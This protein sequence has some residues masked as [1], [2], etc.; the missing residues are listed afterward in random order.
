MTA[1]ATT[2]SFLNPQELIDSSRPL[3]VRVPT[4]P[5]LLMGLFVLLL[6]SSSSQEPAIRVLQFA[7]LPLLLLMSI[8]L[9]VFRVRLARRA[10]AESEAVAALDEMIQLRRWPEAASLAHRVLSQPMFLPD[11]RLFALMSLAALLARYHRFSDAR[12]VHDTLLNPAPGEMVPD[13]SLAHSIKVARAMSLLRDDHLVDADRAMSDLRREVNQARD[14]IRRE[15]GTEPAGRVQSA[16]VVLLD[17]YRDV[18]TGHPQEAIEV[19]HKAMPML[20]DQLGVRVADAWVLLAAAHHALRQHE[21][22]AAAY[23]NATALV[24]AVELHRRYPETRS[25]ADTCTP[26]AWPNA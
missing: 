7:T 3:G 21:A 19:F 17:L 23:A 5:L 11:R 4:W 14:E 9:T 15:S 6:L 8:G 25:L 20:R 12:I 16:G 2:T 18:K 13:P 24:P 22:A 1:D 10:A 26:T